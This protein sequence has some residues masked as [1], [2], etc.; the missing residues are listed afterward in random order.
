M[1]VSKCRQSGLVVIQ[2]PTG[3]EFDELHTV[4]VKWEEQGTNPRNDFE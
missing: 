4:G 2:S 3:F 1:F